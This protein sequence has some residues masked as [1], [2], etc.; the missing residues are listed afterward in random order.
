MA[1]VVNFFMFAKSIIEFIHPGT[2]AA[3]RLF[4]T[5]PLYSRVMGEI[6]Y[7]ELSELLSLVMVAKTMED[8]VLDQAWRCVLKDYP[9]LK[10]TWD[11]NREVEA[12]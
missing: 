6:G 1:S 7:M 4:A 9:E 2:Y 3:A 8:D 11:I 12:A 5:N 10:W